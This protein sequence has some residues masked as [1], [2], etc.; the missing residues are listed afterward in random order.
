MLRSR[1]LPLT[2]ALSVALVS[3]PV[4]ALAHDELTGTDPEDGTTA[5][6]PEDLTLSFSGAIS[7]VG[8]A[9]QVTGPDGE[10][11]SDGDPEVDGST[12]VQDLADDLPDGDYEVVWRVTSEDGHPIAGELA[13]SV[14][15]GAAETEDDDDDTAADEETD[16]AVAAPAPSESEEEPT[17]EQSADASDEAAEEQTAPTEE[18]TDDSSEAST[19][20]PSGLPGWAWAFVGVSAL[21]L[22]VALG[23][24]WRRGR[25]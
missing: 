17:D 12:V 9:V 14:T 10:S 7:E 3:T 22:I 13:F 8:A 21:A 18:S 6:A 24:M 1:R 5:E 4:A 19:A 25:P 23:V 15:G 20:G 11:A 2:L 16:D